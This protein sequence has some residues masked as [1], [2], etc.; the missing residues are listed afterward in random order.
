MRRRDIPLGITYLRRI[1]W[2]VWNGKVVPNDLYAVYFKNGVFRFLQLDW[3]KVYHWGFPYGPLPTS[4]SWEVVSG[5]T[6]DAQFFQDPESGW[7]TLGQFGYLPPW[8]NLF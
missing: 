7:N 5:S 2:T 1:N 6:V 4:V 8:P 3:D